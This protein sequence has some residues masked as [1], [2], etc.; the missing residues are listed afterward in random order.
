[1]TCII[2][3]LDSTTLREFLREFFNVPQDTSEK[4]M[5]Y[6]QTEKKNRNSLDT[7][8]KEVI[9]QVC[10]PRPP[11]CNEKLHSF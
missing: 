2:F 10:F 9:Y 6:I 5:P 8:D 3:L 11:I 4:L 1:M 7:S